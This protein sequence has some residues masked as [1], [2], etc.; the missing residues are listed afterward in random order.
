MVEVGLAF[1]VFL[2]PFVLLTVL[3]SALGGF[4][5]LSAGRWRRRPSL[6]S[7]RTEVRTDA[8]APVL[9]SDLERDEVVQAISRAVGEGRLHLE[10]AERRIGAA[11]ESRHRHDLAQLVQDLPQPSQPTPSP[12]PRRVLLA[13]A[14]VSILVALAAQAA[15]GL[16][17][18]WPVAVA[19]CAVWG[20]R[21]QR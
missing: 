7:P 8:R 19:A 4:T 12:G 10:E 2:S 18:L 11:L 20:A 13:A 6:D 21:P 15:T 16:W 14:V 17:E 3:T 1:L 5:G 9:A